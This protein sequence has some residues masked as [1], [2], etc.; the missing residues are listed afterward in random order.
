MVGESNGGDILQRLEQEHIQLMHTHEVS[1]T[2]IV[3]LSLL[4]MIEAGSEL[5]NERSYDAVV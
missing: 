2:S 5:V 1:G 4:S 3:A